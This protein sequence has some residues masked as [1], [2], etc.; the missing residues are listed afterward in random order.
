M[1]DGMT[2]EQLAVLQ[3]PYAERLD[4]PLLARDYDRVGGEGGV[5]YRSRNDRK[6]AHDRNVFKTAYF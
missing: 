5:T 2:P 1:T 3:P 6:K 4:R